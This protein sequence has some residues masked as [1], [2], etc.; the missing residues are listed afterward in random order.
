MDPRYLRALDRKLQFNLNAIATKKHEAKKR[1]ENVRRRQDDEWR[2]LQSVHIAIIG[3]GIG[4]LAVSLALSHRGIRNTVFEKD[5]SFDARKQG[6]GLTLQQ[7]SHSIKALRLGDAVSRASAWSSR[8]FVFDH[9]GNV[10]AFWGPTWNAQY[11][12]AEKE[13]EEKGDNAEKVEEE[14]EEEKKRNNEEKSA[15]KV[16]KKRRVLPQDAAGVAPQSSSDSSSS[17]AA[18]AAAWQ[19]VR[20]HNLHIPRQY[21]RNI[22]LTH[23][24]QV[25]LCT[26]AYAS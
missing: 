15:K 13:K 8:H 21:L 6:Y 22:L 3:G 19:E 7:G 12:A 11:T 5:G 14:E 17:S 26:S 18:A 1:R 23:A 20:G 9:Q 10:V 4:G 16:C 2:R 25:R 24:V